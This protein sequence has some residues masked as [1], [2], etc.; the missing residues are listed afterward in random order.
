MDPAQAVA[1]AG[2]STVTIPLGNKP[3]A[4]PYYSLGREICQN[5]YLEQAQ[6]EF[7]KADY[8]LIK[9]PGLRRFAAT[10]DAVNLGA[11]RGILTAGN[12]RT[13]A[14]QG[15]ALVEILADGTKSIFGTI[16]TFQGSVS[17]A[18][19]GS[20][21]IIV[22][23]RDGWI[24]RFS[25][26]NFTQITD[27]YFPSNALGTVAPT[28][29]TYLDTYFIVNIPNT[30]QYFYS[31]SYYGNDDT[32]LPYDPLV[33]NG[34]WNPLQSGQKIG[35]PD[36]ITALINCNNYLWLFGVNSCE[37]HYDTGNYNGQ[38]FARYQGAILN[39][40]CATPYS[41]AV[42]QNN[43]FF[44][45]SDKDGTVGVFSNDGMNPV[46]IS[47]RGIEQMIQNMATWEDC[48]AYA[49]AQ[50]GHS[51][52]VM[53]FPAGNKTLVYDTVTNAWHER[54]KL[55]A[56]SGLYVRWD[57]MYATTN[58]GKCIVGDASTS[59]LYDLDPLYYL[60]DN[61]LA[62]GYNYIR[63]VK[64]T[65]IGFQVGKR[66][67][68]NWAQIICNQG[69]GLATNTV[70]GVGVD[71][72]VQLAW[73]NDSG[74]TYSNERPAPIGRQGEYLKRSIVLSCGMSRNRV[75]RIAMTDPVPF[76]LVAILVNG[77]PCRD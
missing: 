57:G 61:P 24:L 19:N 18:E 68:Y 39:V 10:I 47:T 4:T 13:F 20:L 49:Y 66:V 37:I 54:T 45:G 62:T 59:E 17:M 23:G 64:T 3:F 55:N 29:V 21:M 50:N 36:N 74:V 40:G 22:D 12:E 72:T 73:S 27:E 30:N 26:G 41:V 6:T 69:T 33:P 31:T 28:H 77:N 76:I 14:V 38:L 25:D 16:N 42:Y 65:P 8:Y 15:A 7:S 63:C 48:R 32:S 34:Y 71:P 53:Q 35:K 2:A 58:F 56:Q 1:A 11:C 67:R 70:A 43:V 52:Y 44:L 46:R 9:I 5:M 60:N 51:F 75:W